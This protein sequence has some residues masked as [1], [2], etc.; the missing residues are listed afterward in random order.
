MYWIKNWNWDEKIFYLTCIAIFLWI[1]KMILERFLNSRQA[2]QRHLTIFALRFR[3][4]T[5][6]FAQARDFVQLLT[7]PS[8]I[9]SVLYKFL[10]WMVTKNHLVWVIP[11]QNSSDILEI[12]CRQRFVD[13]HVLH[14]NLNLSEL[15]WPMIFRPLERTEGWSVGPWSLFIIILRSNT[16]LRQCDKR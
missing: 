10:N 3:N 9:P 16:T 12:H 8:N 2:Q 7:Y 1:I 11:I 15:Q 6:Q 4:D 13:F 14:L 5:H